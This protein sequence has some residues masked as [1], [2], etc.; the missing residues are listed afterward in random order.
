MSHLSE[1][2][3]KR[4]SAVLI[5]CVTVLVALATFSQNQ[6]SNRA[7]GLAR[8]SQDA[9]IRATGE[10]TRGQQ[11]AA[12]DY[13]A[14]VALRDELYTLA[15]RANSSRQDPLGLAYLNAG[16]ELQPLS[17]LLAESYSHYD[18][19]GFREATDYG[20]YE[21]ETYIVQAALLSEQRAAFAQEGNTWNAKGDNYVAIIAILAVALFLLGLSITLSGS[22]RFLFVGVGL[23]ISGSAA[24]WL[25]LNALQ[26][27]RHVPNAALERFAAG[28]GYGAQAADYIA[29]DDAE[30]YRH[31]NEYWQKA[32]DAYG[33]A[34]QLDPAYANAYDA[35]GL[36][37]LQLIPAQTQA[38]VADFEEA[39]RKGKGEYTT[40]WNYGAAL[41]R[42]GAFERVRAP[43][44]KA[45][46]L[47]ARICGPH[48]NIALALLAQGKLDDAATEYERAFKRC[49]DIYQDAKKRGEK[50]PYS[51]WSSMQAAAYDLDNLICALGKA[52]CYPNRDLPKL[53]KVENGAAARAE[54]LRRRVKEALTAL[55]FNGTT[56]VPRTG[57]RIEQLAFTYRLLD[58][59]GEFANYARRDIFPYNRGEE[60]ILMLAKHAGMSREMFVVWKVLRD[61]NEESG[62]RYADKWTL[63]TEGDA[64][65]KVNS[66]YVLRPGLYE[67]EVYANGELLTT[68]SFVISDKTAA[69]LK[70]PLPA[71]ARP[72]APVP[73]GALIFADDFDNN[74]ANWWTG[75]P[76]S[77]QESVIDGKF[78]LVTRAQERTFLSTCAECGRLNDFY[79][80][81]DTRYVS[82]PTNYGYGLVFRG[83]SGLDRFYSF[84]IDGGG[85]Y[86]IEKLV[87]DWTTLVGWTP[88]AL[89]NQNGANKLGVL[90][91]GDTFEFYINGQFVTRLRDKALPSGAIGVGVNY[92]NVQAAFDNVRVW[93][94]K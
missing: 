73:V 75:S 40:Y 68:G 94:L 86:R 16:K 19:T 61:G 9:A 54:I 32:I 87:D 74:N 10:R 46:A 79:F 93:A 67:L 35:R 41:Y 69:E 55:E 3:Y 76:A 7:A 90:C 24:A 21:A 17:P 62:L 72:A 22:A 91:R 1:E 44:E 14:V 66:W 71:E 25:F 70:T 52:R 26:P 60:E 85:A 8:A 42:Q 43:S 51:L 81:A 77:R 84:A 39:I 23:L 11:R 5:A 28:E 2:Q 89:I 27:V 4:W 83:S 82:G 92:T 58:D 38:A 78:T 37:R 49:D 53:T 33:A 47:N 65:K 30:Y 13:Y 64:V 57:A 56:N 50:P 45:L 59:K 80:E 15:V 34:L 6:A 63:D 48:L 31:A 18:H 36:A 88:S 12:Y 20:R 29:G